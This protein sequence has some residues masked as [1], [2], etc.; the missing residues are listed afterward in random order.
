MSSLPIRELLRQAGWVPAAVF[1]FHA[2]LSLSGAYQRHPA[3]DIPMH[4][5]GGAAIAFFFDRCFVRLARP[6][7]SLQIV[8]IVRNSVVFALTVSAATFWEF[9]EFLFDRAFGTHTQAGLEDTLFDMVLGIIGG[10][11][12]LCAAAWASRART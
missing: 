1:G 11:S 10:V 3:L 9:G 8:N 4:I 2:V 6:E 7:V 5:V 12:Y